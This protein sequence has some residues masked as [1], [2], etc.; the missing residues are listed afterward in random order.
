MKEVNERAGATNVSVD[1]EF[2]YLPVLFS[3]YD[4]Q[5]SICNVFTCVSLFL[6][7]NIISTW[8]YFNFLYSQSYFNMHQNT[9]GKH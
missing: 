6:N 4:R 9:P 1:I 3:Y 5:E 8:R 2:Y 7:I